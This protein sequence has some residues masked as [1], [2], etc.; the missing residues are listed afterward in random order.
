[1]KAEQL[2]LYAVV[3]YFIY[4]FLNR[5]NVSSAIPLAPIAC[6]LPSGGIGYQQSIGPAGTICMPPTAALQSYAVTSS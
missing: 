4:S 3:G 5:S 1:M 6:N 2:L